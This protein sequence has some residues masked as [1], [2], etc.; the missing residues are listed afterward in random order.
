M[1]C[2]SQPGSTVLHPGVKRRA[3]GFAVLAVA[4]FA[5]SR[6]ETLRGQDKVG[7]REDP[8]PPPPSAATPAVFPAQPQLTP[9][10]AVPAPQPMAPVRR[11][12]FTI[13]PNT[14]LKDLLPTPPK[15]APHTE[16]QVADNLMRV[17]EVEFQTAIKK[18]LPVEEALK[19][20]AHAIAKINHLNARKSDHFME[21]LRGQRPDLDG[22]PFAMGDACRTKGERSREFARA[23][24]LVRGAMR[25]RVFV[26]VQQV[27]SNMSPPG[28]AAVPV[29]SV[30]RTMTVEPEDRS[31]AEYFWEQYQ[32]A[33]V[34]D[35]R[36]LG[37]IDQSQRDHVILA[38]IAALMQV[39]APEAPS[40]RLG[41]VQHLATISHVE[42]TRALARL[43]IFSAEEEVRKAAAEALKVRRERDYTDI[44]VQGLRYPWPTVARNAADVIVRLERTD[45]QPELVGLLEEP[46]P[47]APCIQ[48]TDGKK[49]PVIRELVRINHHRNCLL[50]HAPGNTGNVSAETLTAAVPVPSEPL[51][52]PSDGYQQSSPDV[53]VRIDVTYLRQD[54]S[55]YQAIAE[56]SPWPEM[57][58]FDFLV[59]TR[60]LTDDEA[61]AF[62]KEL[63]AEQNGRPSPY[64]R[65]ALAALREMTG[66][67][68]DAT[69]ETWRKL[70]KLPVTQ[71][72]AKAGP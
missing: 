5:L 68:G 43:A 8:L 36:R 44:L 12:Q 56:A 64:Q 40:L 9:L 57:Q 16:R 30:P 38:R 2:T 34:Q 20:T 39:L 29:V 66:L 49:A 23:V 65:A 69:A 4:V 10:P 61:T 28:T 41:L 37:K 46:D 3:V 31:L 63:A 50:C 51:P 32:A 7:P 19:Q 11:F 13:A 55:M 6:G 72:Q 67:E 14:P 21:A 1:I 60:T 33:C 45:L 42:A 71:R 59:R 18:D 24:G 35:N 53:L 48:E 47:R 58:R 62:H 22:L 25:S 70:L 15:E 54:F 52:S 26:N 27:A 17:P